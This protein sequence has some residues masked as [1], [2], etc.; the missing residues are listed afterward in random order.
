M[1]PDVLS[2]SPNLCIQLLLLIS[3]LENCLNPP[4]PQI[5]CPKK[6]SH[7]FADNQKERLGIRRSS[8]FAEAEKALD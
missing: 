5:W 6:S 7:L 4:S 8:E 2:K 1:G 3:S